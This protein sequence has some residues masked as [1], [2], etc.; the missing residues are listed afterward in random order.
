MNKTGEAYTE[1]LIGHS[2][3]RDREVLVSLRKV[4]EV[5]VGET[6]NAEMSDQVE[7]HANFL[8]GFGKNGLAE[9][10]NRGMSEE[11]HQE[12]GRPIRFHRTW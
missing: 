8:Y 6:C 10:S 2:G 1:N 12:L 4:V 11:M 5:S 7:A 9:F 3:Y